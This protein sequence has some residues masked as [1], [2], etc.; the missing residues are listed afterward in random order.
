MPVPHML[1]FMAKFFWHTPKFQIHRGKAIQSNKQTPGN[2]ISKVSFHPHEGCREDG[3]EVIVLLLQEK[4]P[5]LENFVL[6]RKQC[7]E[8]QIFQ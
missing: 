6:I 4:L 2:V 1:L 7:R 3:G 8:A 5:Q